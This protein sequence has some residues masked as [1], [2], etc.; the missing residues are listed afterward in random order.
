M[1]I[2]IKPSSQIAC[3]NKWRLADDSMLHKVQTKTSL[4]DLVKTLCQQVQQT[5]TASWFPWAPRERSFLFLVRF[6]YTKFHSMCGK[7]SLGWDPSDQQHFLQFEDWSEVWS[8]Y[9][10]LCGTL[11]GI[12]SPKSIWYLLSKIFLGNTPKTH[13]NPKIIWKLKIDD[14]PLTNHGTI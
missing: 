13:T 14:L 7:V 11:Q 1:R 5:D 12:D 2:V 10:V 4:L 3:S 8:S 9:A 6:S